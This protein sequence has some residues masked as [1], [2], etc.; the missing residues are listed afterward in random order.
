MPVIADDLT[1]WN[2][3]FNWRQHHY[4][5]IS[6]STSGS[7]AIVANLGSQASVQTMIKFGKVARKH[8]LLS[9]AQKSIQGIENVSSADCFQKILQTVK[10]SIQLANYSENSQN[11]LVE[12]LNALESVNMEHIPAEQKAELTAYKGYMYT[13][14]G[15]SP[16][17]NKSFALAT[18]LC[19]NSNKAWALY[20]EYLEIVFSRNPKLHSMGISAITC[21]LHASRDQSETKTRKYLAKA[22][23]LLTYEGTRAEMLKVF[24]N[25][26]LGAPTLNWLPCK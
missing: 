23:W 7:N 20:G 14:L 9:V 4:Q 12:A 8:N 6:E 25:Y 11:D 18:D 1:H 10:C 22:I 26:M 2:D 16:E 17:A 24:E 5:L 21:F 3:I 15:R 13:Y 19:D